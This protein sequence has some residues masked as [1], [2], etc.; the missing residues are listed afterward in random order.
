[1]AKAETF[2]VAASVTLKNVP[3]MTAK[4][5]EDICK[6]LRSIADDVQLHHG[7]YSKS[8]VFRYYFRRHKK[9][10]P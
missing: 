1:M 4:G 2:G 7:S 6:W 8:I 9:C 10:K 3:D 5:R